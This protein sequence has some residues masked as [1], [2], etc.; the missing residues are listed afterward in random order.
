MFGGWGCLLP[1]LAFSPAACSMTLLVLCHLCPVCLPLNQGRFSS[2]G[3]QVT[4]ARWLW[5]SMSG[6]CIGMGRGSFG[7]GGGNRPGG[8]SGPGG[9]LQ[10][11]KQILTHPH[12]WNQSALHRFARIC[13]SFFTRADLNS[14]LV[15]DGELIGIRGEISPNPELP[16]SQLLTCAGYSTGH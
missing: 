3:N 4:K 10:Q 9:W 8:R 5:E 7:R 15:G 6:G 2:Q 11:F 12:S 13:T 1:L 14:L 16:S